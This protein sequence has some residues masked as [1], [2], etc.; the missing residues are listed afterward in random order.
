[1]TL[2]VVGSSPDTIRVARALDLPVAD[3][4]TAVP[5]VVVVTSR[6]DLDAVRTAVAHQEGSVAAVVAVGL[7]EDQVVAAYDIGVPV[8]FGFCSRA[9]LDEAIA[10]GADSER[11]AVAATLASIEH[12]IGAQP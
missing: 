10:A 6:E 11:R 9:E 3:G 5:L 2:A 8:A 4:P 1:M 12:A 7:A